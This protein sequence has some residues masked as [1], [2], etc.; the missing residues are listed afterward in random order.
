MLIR[1]LKT[2]TGLPRGSVSEVDDYTARELIAAG[3]AIEVVP[4]AQQEAA[5]A[6]DNRP[7]VSTGG[8]TGANVPQSSSPEG[9][10]LKTQ[11]SPL[12]DEMVSASL[13]STTDTGS[14]KSAEE[15]QTSSTPATETG[16][17]RKRGRPR[18]KG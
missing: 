12:A 8:R 11:T 18:S 10:V 2:T 3:Y 17:K 9:Q 16:G 15:K 13:P 14:A 1:A 5:P 6:N 7:L 4:L